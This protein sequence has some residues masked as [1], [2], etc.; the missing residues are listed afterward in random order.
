MAA[1]TLK[2][3]NTE[4]GYTWEVA[5]AGLVKT[6]SQSWQAIIYFHQA[7][8]CHQRDVGSLSALQLSRDSILDAASTSPTILDGPSGD[9]K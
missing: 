5:Y 9:C 3:I 7:M 2:R 8:E 6:H 1:P 4:A